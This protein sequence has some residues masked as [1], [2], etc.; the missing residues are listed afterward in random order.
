MSN[1]K[2]S[3]V[4]DV[5]ETSCPTNPA[6]ITTTS[7]KK[8]QPKY[9]ASTSRQEALL[10]QKNDAEEQTNMNRQHAGTAHN[11]SSKSNNASEK[12]S[13]VKPASVKPA[14]E[15]LLMDGNRII[16]PQF[17]GALY[18]AHTGPVNAD[19]LSQ[20]GNTTVTQAQ[21][22]AVYDNLVSTPSYVNEPKKCTSGGKAKKSNYRRKSLAKNKSSKKLKSKKNKSTKKI[23]NTKT[24]KPT[25]K[26]RK[27]KKS[28]NIN[29]IK[30]K[31]INRDLKRKPKST[32]KH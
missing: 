15:K 27:T 10:I 1:E 14:S 28:K 2:T 25:R 21:S 18:T 23:K 32:K 26:T 22:D 7:F 5:F 4:K 20:L 6:K 29:Q 30:K 8:Y 19:S 11:K 9:N 17:P 24:T 31:I 16:I 3:T 13:S 12:P